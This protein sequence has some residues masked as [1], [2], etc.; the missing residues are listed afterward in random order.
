MTWGLVDRNRRTLSVLIV[1][2]PIYFDPEPNPYLI[3]P[4]P[5]QLRPLEKTTPISDSAGK[6]MDT[7]IKADGEREREREREETSSRPQEPENLHK[8]HDGLNLFV[9]PIHTTPSIPSI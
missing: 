8:R 6:D 9:L 3:N 2:L 4:P 7:R 1:S 5:L